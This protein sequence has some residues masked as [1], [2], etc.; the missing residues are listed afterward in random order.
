ML[1]GQ[2]FVSLLDLPY[3]FTTRVSGDLLNPKLTTAAI[4]FVELSEFSVLRFSDM[5]PKCP[6]SDI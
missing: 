5:F 6:S 4:S 3:L 1:G 2:T